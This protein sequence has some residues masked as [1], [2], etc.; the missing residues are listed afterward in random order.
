MQAGYF[1]LAGI[2]CLNNAGQQTDPGTVAQLG[3]LEAQVPNL[4][5]HRPT[6]R[7]PMGVP[8][9][10]KR[11]HFRLTCPRNVR[12]AWQRTWR[13]SP[14]AAVSRS[15]SRN[16]DDCA[17]FSESLRGRSSFSIAAGLSPRTRLFS[18]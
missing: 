14:C 8:T 9:S 16:A 18:I 11:I 3:V 1:D 4:A 2:Y 15:A 13:P 5:Q 10:G 6:V 17:P 12:S 7:V